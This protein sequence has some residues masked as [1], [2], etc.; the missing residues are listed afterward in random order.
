MKFDITHAFV[1]S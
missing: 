1:E